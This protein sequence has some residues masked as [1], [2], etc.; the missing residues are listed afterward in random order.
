MLALIEFEAG[1]GVRTPA[2]QKILACLND[3]NLYLQWRRNFLMTFSVCIAGFDGHMVKA[4]M[5]ILNTTKSRR[6]VVASGLLIWS[7]YKVWALAS[8]WSAAVGAA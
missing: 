6:V 3:M 1:R 8:T 4:A 7:T 5:K 2:T